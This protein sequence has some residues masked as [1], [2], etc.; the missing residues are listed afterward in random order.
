[1]RRSSTARSIGARSDFEEPPVG[2]GIRLDGEG[3]GAVDGKV[4][5]T[6][7]GHENGHVKEASVGTGD[8]D[9]DEE[10]FAER[11]RL[12]RDQLERYSFG[13]RLP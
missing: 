8:V 7:E 9:A 10:A 13:D 1:M 4:R 12:V 11:G 3:D 2:L 6:V 5:E